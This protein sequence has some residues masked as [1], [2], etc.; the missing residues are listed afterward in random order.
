MMFL[1]KPLG[2]LLCCGAGIFCTGC[3][4][5]ETI[6]TGGTIE[7][8][9]TGYLTLRWTIENSASP[10]IC[11]LFRARDLEILI[12]DEYQRKVA[13]FYRSCDDF[14]LTAELPEGAYSANVTLVNRRRRAA[15]TTLP[16]AG[17]RIRAGE[18]TVIRV[19]FPAASRL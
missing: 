5:D 14:E 6:D 4:V 15:S 3:F 2:M 8:Y 19:D 13:Q 1:S 17:I 18:A 16:I 11:G 10:A 9:P 7:P 12:Y